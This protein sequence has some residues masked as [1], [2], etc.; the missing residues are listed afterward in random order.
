ML[1]S[2]IFKNWFGLG[3]FHLF[4][5]LIKPVLLHVNVSGVGTVWNLPN[6]SGQLLTPDAEA[7]PMLAAIGGLNGGNARM[8]NTF[9]FPLNSYYEHETPSQP[10]ISETAS[11]TAPTAISY[12]RAQ[13]SNRTAIFHESVNISYRKQSSAGYMSGVNM[14]GQMNQVPNE[15]FFQIMVALKKMQRDIEYCILQGAYNAATTAATIDKFRGINAAAVLAGNTV[16]ASGAYLSK[17]LIDQL[18][19]TM[20]QAGADFEN[21]AFVC[22]MFQKQL[23]G[24]IYGIAPRDRNIGGVAMQA[25]ETDAGLIGVML[26]KT[27]FQDSQTVSLVD[28]AKCQPVMQP[29]PDKG[30]FFYEELAKTGAAEKGQLYGQF[31]LDYGASWFHGT[32]TG[33]ANS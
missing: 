7:F 19:R 15:K 23:L 17:T 30:N 31:S 29:V 12:V 10:A 1:N 5:N 6:Y 3:I 32:I 33:L 21:C 9:E 28:F 26:A 20:Y 16:A 18:L 22:S 13:Q 24:D 27:E 8:V 25:I 2:S 14:A 4:W 11:L